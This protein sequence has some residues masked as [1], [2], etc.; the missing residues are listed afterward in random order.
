[1]GRSNGVGNTKNPNGAPRQG[2]NGHPGVGEFSD[3]ACKVSG[4]AARIRNYSLDFKNIFIYD[5][6][7][8]DRIIMNFNL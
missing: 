2:L 3:L 5:Y 8:Y 4:M 1:M 6:H 7:Y